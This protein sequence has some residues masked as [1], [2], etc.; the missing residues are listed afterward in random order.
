MNLAGT[1]HVKVRRVA[2]RADLRRFVGLPYRLY[3]NDPVWV[4]PL[5]TEQRKQCD[6]RRNPMLDHCTV[7]LFLAEDGNTHVVGRVAAFVDHLAVR[8]WGDPVGL[9]GSFECSND[10]V[11]S[12][13]L[14]EAAREWLRGQGMR[15]MR[16]PWSFASQEWGLVVEG[17]ERPPVIMAPHNPPWY[18]DH[19]LAFGLAKA[20]DLLVYV[21]DTTEGYRIPE[22]YLTV[23]DLV[24]KRYGITVRPVNMK[25]LEKDIAILV[26][27]ANRSISSNWGFYP[28]TEA[29]GRALARDI[30]PILDPELVLIAEDSAG[31]PIGFAITL[32]DI[33]VLLRGLNGR[34]LPLGWWRLLTGRKRLSQ[35]RM[36]AIGV[37][38]EYQQRA[39]DALLYRRTHDVLNPRGNVRLEANYVLEDNVRMTNAMRNLGLEQI[40]RYRVYE[41]PI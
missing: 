32:P 6:S 10:P 40:R 2:A 19:L 27:V 28:A 35:Y 39:V 16:G 21:A 41:M 30:K 33:N 11:A 1:D 38:P 36:W 3:R 9:F 5:R 18:N 31:E 26:E 24:Q 29:E 15:S 37:V 4:P 12:R 20:K 25:H 22:R 14:L 7:E 8:H 13:L 23:T 34:L 17:F